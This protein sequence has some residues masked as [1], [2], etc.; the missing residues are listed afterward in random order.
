MP[1]FRYQSGALGDPRL[2]RG[3]V[4]A[5]AN[6][7]LDLH[8]L[9]LARAEGEIAG[10]DFVAEG[11]ANLGDAKGQLSAHGIEHVAEVDVDALR[12]FGPHVDQPRIVARIHGAD[13]GAEHEI[14]GTRGRQ[15]LRTTFGTGNL[16]GLDGGI[17]FGQALGVSPLLRREHVIRAR[18][19]LA[20]AAVRHRIGEGR[21]VA[22]VLPH[23]AIHQNGGVEP[24]HVVALV[25]DRAPPGALDVVLQFDAQR[26]VVPGA[27][28]TAVDRR[29]WKHES[30][31]F[32][33]T[34][35]G[36][37]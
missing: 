36:V 7:V 8:L 33:E 1:S 27:A 30:T 6:E 23:Q 25:H 15:I 37:E 10:C 28:E 3:L 13:A 4:L 11:L 26:T 35:D 14:E 19:R 32:A 16:L 2:V 5:G 9:E 24:F 29:R 22:R 17:D 31:A 12:G 18:P 21:L 34:D 20:R